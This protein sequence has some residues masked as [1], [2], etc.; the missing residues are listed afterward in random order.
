M[1]FL[2]GLGL[3]ITFCIASKTNVWLTGRGGFGAKAAYRRACEEL[4]R[5]GRT[6]VE[7]NFSAKLFGTGPIVLNADGFTLKA[8]KTALT[9]A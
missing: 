3:A 6:S 4:D 7:A 2:H 1:T 8:S 9:Y 5:N